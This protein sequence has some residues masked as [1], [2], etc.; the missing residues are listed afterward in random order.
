MSEESGTLSAYP[1]LCGLENRP[2]RE[3][4]KMKGRK[5]TDRL[6]KGRAVEVMKKVPKSSVLVGVIIVLIL[7]A[8]LVTAVFYKYIDNLLFEERRVHL[9]EITEKITQVV[10]TVTEVSWERTEICG[11]LLQL[12]DMQDEAAVLENLD[13]IED[14]LLSEDTTVFALGENQEYYASNGKSGVWEGLP[15]MTDLEKEQQIIITKLP[16][17]EEER[18]IF[19]RRLPERQKVGDSGKYLTHIATAVSMESMQVIFQVEGFGTNCYTYIINHEG[20]DIYHNGEGSNV[21]DSNYLLDSMGKYRFVHGGTLEDLE[22]SIKEGLSDSYEFEYRDRSY[23]VSTAPV[24]FEEWTV[25]VFVPTVVLGASTSK[26]MNIA[27][28]YFLV[29]ALIIVLLFS[30]TVFSV[31]KSRGDKRMLKQQEEAKRKLARMAKEA[32]AAS[33]AK[34]AFLSHM[35]H[36]IRTPINGIMGMTGIAMK[37]LEDKEQV[38]ECLK[39]ID[40][41]SSHLLSLVNDVLD[42]G[43]HCFCQYWM[44]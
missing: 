3:A 9:A 4:E 12:H 7:L 25:L 35:S 40:D 26:I 27:V 34:S 32:R 20:K 33:A 15:G 31:T 10:D 42:I 13:M 43:Y 17:E 16:Y 41:S 29:I 5:E 24:F 1:F 6:Q 28:I 21:I 2:M 18:M 11:N 22:N 19:L 37:N 44:H 36:D 38:E 39:K 30:A 14:F 23:F 8:L